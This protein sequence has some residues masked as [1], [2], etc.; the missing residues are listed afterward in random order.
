MTTPAI[1]PPD[2][3]KAAMDAYDRLWKDGQTISYA[4]VVEAF[5][6]VILEERARCAKE[7]PRDPDR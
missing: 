7:A 2:V 4:K 6:N 5:C 1:I 3:A